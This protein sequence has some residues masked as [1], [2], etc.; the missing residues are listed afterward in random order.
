MTLCP[1]CLQYLPD[2]ACITCVGFLTT[3][4]SQA[5]SPA[6]GVDAYVGSEVPPYPAAGCSPEQC[7]AAVS[8]APA[9]TVNDPVPAGAKSPPSTAAGVS[10]SAIE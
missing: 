5:Y 6:K 4:K 1:H 7:A 9:A 10:S 2:C 3:S 8:W